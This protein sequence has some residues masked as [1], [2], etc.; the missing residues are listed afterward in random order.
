MKRLTPTRTIASQQGVAAVEFAIVLPLL[1]LIFTGMVEYGRLMWHY[2]ALAKATRDAARFLV[3]EPAPMTGDK[4]TS[5]MKDDAREMV[6][7]AAMA[8]GVK[9][10]AEDSV[11][12]PI[13][14]SPNCT[15]PQ[16]VTVR[17]SYPF[18]IGGWIP[19]IGPLA[20]TN[21]TLSPHTTMRYMR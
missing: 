2:D 7:D 11:G 13:T 10:L 20:I 1:A 19:V 15:A 3:E 8:A 9:G 6:G 5:G 14:C 21:V 18:T 16:T 12:I 17:V 4:I